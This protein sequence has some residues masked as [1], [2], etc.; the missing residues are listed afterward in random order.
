MKYLCLLFIA[1]IT[2]GFCLVANPTVIR[3]QSNPAMSPEEHG[4]A[5]TADT[6]NLSKYSF[7]A[8]DAQASAI[9]N[10]L[11]GVY[12][13]NGNPVISGVL[14]IT[15]QLLAHMVTEPP[16]QT[17]YYVA[18]L[19]HNGGFIAQPVYAQG[20]GFS[21]LSPIL[22]VWKAFR[23]LAYFLFILIFIVVGVMIMFRAQLNPQT[24][25]TV[26]A[27]LP[28]IVVTLILI[29][30]SYAIAGLVVDLIYLLFFVV[31]SLLETFGILNNAGNTRDV[32]FGYSIFRIGFKYLI[33]PFEAAGDASRAAGNLFSSALGIP[34]GLQGIASSIFYLIVMVAIVIAMFRTLFALLIA[35]ISIILGVIFAPLQLLLNAIPGINTFSSWIRGLAANAF[36]FPA[37]GIMLI[38]GVALTGSQSPQITQEFGI[39]T[40]APSGGGSGTGWVPPLITTATPG[41]T[42]TSQITAVIGMGIIMLLPEVIKLVKKA[43]AVQ[44][45]GIGEMIQGNLQRG[46]GPINS[47]IGRPVAMVSSAA[48]G[49]IGHEFGSRFYRNYLERKATNTIEK[50]NTPP[51]P[52]N[53][54][55]DWTPPGSTIPGSSKA[56]KPATPK[57]KSTLQ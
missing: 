32:L 43:F 9:G 51:A 5:T 28:K 17:G 41:R 14:P 21:A 24:V 57:I 19:M 39:N 18:D 26:Q 36:V 35:W 34:R 15:A 16:V 48:V 2:L 33:S 37:V 49:Q 30:F 55:P 29:T 4:S 3:A 56:G 54:P 44:D 46:T 40:Q 1:L 22:Q 52:E 12:D 10:G 38:V 53:F 6:E 45:S 42:G 27:A 13:E 7:E 11:G 8:V 20:I 47:L 50:D 25:V 23:N 31:T